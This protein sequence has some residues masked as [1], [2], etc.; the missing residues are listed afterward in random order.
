[1]KCSNIKTGASEDLGQIQVLFITGESVKKN[2]C[3]MGAFARRSIHHA[4]E[5]FSAFV[6]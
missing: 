6:K 1:M 4:V 3:R 5:L 2:N